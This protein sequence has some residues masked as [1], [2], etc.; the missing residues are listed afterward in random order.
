MGEARRKKLT[1]KNMLGYNQTVMKSQSLDH[2]T[3]SI[4]NK[5]FWTSR[6]FLSAALWALGNWMVRYGNNVRDLHN[7][8]EQCQ[9]R[10]SYRYSDDRT[11]L[12]KCVLCY[13]SFHVKQSS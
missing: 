6:R 2:Y 8:I 13:N 12:Y 4:R 5:F 3:E 10:V 9:H 1:Q 11:G 7:E